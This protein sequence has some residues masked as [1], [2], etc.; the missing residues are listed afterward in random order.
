MLPRDSPRAIRIRT[1]ALFPAKP[2]DWNRGAGRPLPDRPDGV[3][4]IVPVYFA[5]GDLARCVAS[6]AAETDLVLHQVF[7]VADGPQDDAVEAVFRELISAHPSRVQ[8]LRNP[9]RRG[10]VETANR[11]MRASTRDVVLLNSDTV[12]TARWLEKLIDAASSSGDIGTVTPL[13]N[14]ATLC[15]VPRGFEENLLPSGYDAASFGA[16]VERVSL[17]TRPRLPT[18]VGV[19]MYI[20]RALLDETG[21]FAAEAFGLGYGEENDFCMRA[22]ARGWLHVADDATFV[23]HAGHRSFRGERVALQRA[24]ARTLA[25]R[26]P[27][28][29]PTIG[30][31]MAEDPLA[32]VRARICASLSRRVSAP[33]RSPGRIVH[34]VHGWPPFQQAGTEL[35]ARWLVREQQDMREVSVFARYDDPAHDQGAA[36]ELIDEGVRVRLVTNNFVQRDPFARNGLRDS[37]FE[38]A[39]E[40]FLDEE[41]PDLLHVHHLA[42]HAFSLPALARKRGIRVV[43]QLQDWWFLC[44]RVNLLHASGNRC[45]GPKIGKCAACAP[46]TRIAPS[47]VLNR[48]LHVARRSAARGAL[49]AADAYVMG[50]RAIREDYERTGL[51][52]K[53]RPRFVL[54]YGVG[55]PATA[56]RAARSFPLRFGF[57][58][59]ILPHKG[60]HVAVE[61]F[62]GIDPA[63]ATLEAWGNAEAS[64]GYTR[65]LLDR[66]QDAPFTLHPP[67]AEESKGAVFASIDVLLIPSIGLESFGL[68]AREAMAAKVPVIATND[69]A[70]AEMFAPGSCGALFPSG[71]AR[72]LRSIVDELVARPSL[73]DVWS[74]RLPAPLSVAE[75]AAALEDVYATVLAG[76]T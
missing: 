59:S 38:R 15:S 32:P 55:L 61:A 48:L 25:R 28:Y 62:R 49:R 20:R 73:A 30:A 50:S 42:G 70:L 63:A 8:V 36:V 65:S 13:S 19:C 1:V 6:L 31:F 45:S 9:E 12:V 76:K 57:I 51:L 46:L 54:P 52:V 2:L 56:T 64:P 18:A 10:F 71:D 24:A 60:L 17:R 44:A 75:H 43:Q 66:G 41:R 3:D 27:A 67:F 53:G 16:L 74:Q 39:F 47:A 4:I 40:R 37:M 22:L 34:L 26:H 35:Y 23:F 69:G 5:A 58:G 14:H 7:L 33:R 11:G 21:L 29:L 72:A 68:V